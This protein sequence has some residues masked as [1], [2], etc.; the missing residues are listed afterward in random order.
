MLIGIEG[1][2]FLERYVAASR[3]EAAWM[4]KTDGMMFRLTDGTNVK[5]GCETDWNDVVD[6]GPSHSPG[7]ARH[8]L[9]HGDA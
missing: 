8:G 5:A 9:S 6:S 4:D 7:R 3:V 1:E 2:G